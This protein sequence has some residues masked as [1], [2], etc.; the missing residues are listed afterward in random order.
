[1][2]VGVTKEHAANFLRNPENVQKAREFLQ[3]AK[4]LRLGLEDTMAVIRRR[5]TIR[6]VPPN[7]I[8]AALEKLYARENLSEDEVHM[9]NYLFP[10]ASS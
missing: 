4:S 6:S 3:L 5:G 10:G 7:D 1:M 2:A 8:Q 9:I